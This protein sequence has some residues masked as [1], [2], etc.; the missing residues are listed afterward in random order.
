[1]SIEQLTPERIGIGAFI[2]LYITK[3]VIVPL[4]VKFFPHFFKKADREQDRQ[5]DRLKFDQQ[6]QLRQI[7]AWESTA[8]SNAEISKVLGIMNVNIEY[9]V[10][11]TE[12]QKTKPVKK[13]QG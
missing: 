1:M 13:Q 3:E 5:D 6:M 8:K 11:M 10:R 2:L 9:L 7:E 12:I 4:T